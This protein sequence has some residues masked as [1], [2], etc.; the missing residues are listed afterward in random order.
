MSKDVIVAR[1]M[2]S[3]GLIGD[4]VLFEN[5]FTARVGPQR[6]EFGVGHGPGKRE[7]APDHPEQEN[8]PRVRDQLRDEDRDEEDAAADDVGNNDGGRV[9]GAEAPVK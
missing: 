1:E 4:L 6:G 5:V 7:P 9:Q 2:L 3:A 8:G